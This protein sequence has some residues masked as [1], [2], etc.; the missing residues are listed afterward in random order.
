MAA[1]ETNGPCRWCGHVHGVLCPYVKAYEY[2]AEGRIT[3]V[4]FLTPVDYHP[5]KLSQAASADA[6]DGPGY[7]TLGRI[8]PGT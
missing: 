8:T 3:R 2:D 7:P 4:E 6:D 1:P 5:T